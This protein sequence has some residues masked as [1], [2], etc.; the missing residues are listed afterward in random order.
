MALVNALHDCLFFLNAKYYELPNRIA[1]VR[2]INIFPSNEAQFNYR[3]VAYVIMTTLTIKLCGFIW[4]V[5]STI[6]NLRNSFD[7]HSELD[8]AERKK[9]ELLQDS[10]D[11]KICFDS[12]KS[13]TSTPCGHLFCWD[14]ILKYAQIKTEC[15]ICRTSLQPKQ[16]IRV[17]NLS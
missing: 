16:L 1:R 4:N 15:P 8:E 10:L 14:C 11:C 7:S 5:R 6:K 17:A 2:Y 9:F 3:V 12:R 13:T